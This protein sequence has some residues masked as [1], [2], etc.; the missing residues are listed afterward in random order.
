MQCHHTRTYVLHHRV[1]GTVVRYVLSHSDD[2][3]RCEEGQRH[4]RRV[5]ILG[6]DRIRY[7]ASWA[8]INLMTVEPVFIS[9]VTS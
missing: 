6:I 5:G 7:G 4:S 2:T 1:S 9:A 3:I 8:T